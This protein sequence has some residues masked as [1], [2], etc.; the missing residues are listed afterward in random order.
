MINKNLQRQKR[1]KTKKIFSIGFT[2]ILIILG[3]FAGTASACYEGCTIGFWKNHEEAWVATGLSPDGT[4]GD[5]F[6]LPGKFSDFED[7]K[8]IDALK[9]KGGRGIEG[10]FRLLIKQAVAAALNIRHP[11]VNYWYPSF[12]DFETFR[13]QTAT[14]LEGDDRPGLVAAAD[15]LDQYNNMGCPEGCI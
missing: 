5:L 1:M 8:L 9:F 11:C 12:V 13:T 3:I 6:D 4:V 15:F 14:H 2:S 10:G 7:V